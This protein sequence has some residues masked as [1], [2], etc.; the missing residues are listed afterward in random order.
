[1]LQLFLDNP[2][3]IFRAIIDVKNCRIDATDFCIPQG[4]ATQD[5]WTLGIEPFRDNCR[6]VSLQKDQPSLIEAAGPLGDPFSQG[7]EDVAEKRCRFFFALTS[8]LTVGAENKYCDILSVV[9]DP[10]FPV[11]ISVVL[12]KGSNL[13]EPISIATLNFQQSDSLPELR[14][15]VIQ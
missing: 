1:M 5:F 15:N 9:G 11:P 14:K 13:T 4:G 3:S 7:L 6:T 2:I 8:T 10:F 12:P